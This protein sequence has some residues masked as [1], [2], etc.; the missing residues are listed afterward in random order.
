MRR[1]TTEAPRPAPASISSWPV[2][3][4]AAAALATSLVVRGRR[5]SLR[6]LAASLAVAAAAEAAAIRGMRVLRHHGR[7]QLAGLPLVLPLGWYAYIA[8]AY[9][10]AQAALG[11]VGA[12]AVAAATALLA[13]ATDLANDPWGLDSGYWEWRDGGPYLRD[14]VG[15]NGIAGIP[16]GN[17]VV[18]LA[19]AGSVALLCEAGRPDGEVAA[20]RR[21]RTLLL[22]TYVPLGLGGLR[23]ALGT[24]HLRLL[25]V[26]AIAV[27]GG[28]A[29]AWVAAGRRG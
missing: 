17:F 11:D 8:P 4:L 28:G 9:G 10:L 16:L 24:Q 6:L 12:P 3:A 22:A 1:A 25:A 18:W 27:F 20:A 7:P 29:A 14:V 5:R 21:H 2:A 23:W 15:P 13:T 19:V 26:A